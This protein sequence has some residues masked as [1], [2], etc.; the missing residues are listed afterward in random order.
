MESELLA[1]LSWALKSSVN[2]CFRVL[3]WA[4]GTASSTASL[5]ARASRKSGGIWL[6]SVTWRTYLIQTAAVLVR[7]FPA[8]MRY[9][10]VPWPASLSCTATVLS[11]SAG[12]TYW[13]SNPLTGAADSRASFCRLMPKFHSWPRSRSS[14]SL[15]YCWLHAMARLFDSVIEV[16]KSV[17]PIL[18]RAEL[19]IPTSEA[20]AQ[21]LF[22]AGWPASRPPR[23]EKFIVPPSSYPGNTEGRISC[24]A[25]ARSP[26]PGS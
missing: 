1:R 14:R 25:G 2:C 21:F 9:A 22:T 3:D 7:I 12:S 13:K 4:M 17:R 20:T 26:V 24:R 8:S 16:M 6:A 23:A 10:A 5:Y 18:E 11:Q 15:A 19:Q